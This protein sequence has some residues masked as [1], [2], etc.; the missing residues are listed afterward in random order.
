MSIAGTEWKLFS[1][2]MFSLCCYNLLSLALPKLQGA[3]LDAVVNDKGVKFDR[4][5]ELYLF[6]SIGVGFLG[7]IQSLC[8]S[9]VGRKIAKTIRLRLFTGIIIQVCGPFLT[10]L[11]CIVNLT[12]HINEVIASCT[13]LGCGVLRREQQWSAVLPTHQRCQLHGAAHSVHDGVH[14]EQQHPAG[15][16]NRHVF[17][18]VLAAIDA[19]FH[20]HWANRARHSGLFLISHKVRNHCQAFNCVR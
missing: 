15:G 12:C 8:F 9:V 10:S 19:R 17:L 18:H 3:I 7:G 16:R 20:H 13:P 2:A 6:V 5:V 14:A 1:I 11:P 4:N